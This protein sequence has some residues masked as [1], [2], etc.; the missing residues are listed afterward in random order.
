MLYSLK[1]KGAWSETAAASPETDDL[2]LALLQK[3]AGSIT[4]F[5]LQIFNNYQTSGKGI[6]TLNFNGVKAS[7]ETISNGTYFIHRRLNVMTDGKPAG[8][9][10]TFV[11]FMLSGQGQHLV[12]DAGFLPIQ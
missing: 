11:D 5:P 4:F 7:K 3:T 1:G 12:I 10:K 2:A 6:K 9:T 8:A